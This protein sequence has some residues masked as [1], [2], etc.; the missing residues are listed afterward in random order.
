MLTRGRVSR[1]QVT[2]TS[3]R[4]LFV[5]F[6]AEVLRQEQDSLARTFDSARDI[7]NLGVAI[8][9]LPAP[10]A[11]IALHSQY[12]VRLMPSLRQDMEVSRDILT[13]GLRCRRRAE[14]QLWRRHGR[15]KFVAGKLKGIR[16]GCN[17]SAFNFAMKLYAQFL[18]LSAFGS[19]AA[20]ARKCWRPSAYECGRAPSK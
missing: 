8:K 6:M 9:A 14:R 20:T 12:H 7:G 19:F 10:V 16:V 15:P 13:L 17:R 3:S 1:V 18:L 4:W 11:A 5:L 2:W